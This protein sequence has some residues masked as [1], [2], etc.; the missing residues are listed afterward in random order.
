MGGSKTGRSGTLGPA[1]RDIIDAG[2]DVYLDG[3]KTGRSG[4]GCSNS[5]SI[6]SD[7]GLGSSRNDVALGDGLGENLNGVGA[8]ADKRTIDFKPVATLDVR[9]ADWSARAGPSIDA[10]TA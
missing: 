6:R 9:E 10:E 7:S 5:A 4:R 8:S 1:A 3:S 2:A